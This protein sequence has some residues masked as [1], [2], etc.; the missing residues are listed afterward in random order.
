MISLLFLLTLLVLPFFISPFLSGI[1]SKS[2][3]ILR[4]YAINNVE[5]QTC[6]FVANPV[7]D[8]AGTNGVRVDFRWPDAEGGDYYLC[9]ADEPGP[10]DQFIYVGWNTSYSV[11]NLLQNRRYLW[12]V[13]S[14]WLSSLSPTQG[15]FTTPDCAPAPTNNAS[16]GGI[17]A[18]DSVTAGQSFSASVTMQNTG[19]KAWTTD[20]TPHNLG[21]QNLPDNWTWGT[22]RVGLPSSPIN[23]GQSATFSSNFT[24]PTTP[25]TY[26]FSWKMV[27]DGVDWFGETCSKNITV[28]ATPKSHI[29]LSPTSFSFTGVSGGATPSG[30]TLNIGNTGNATLGWTGSTNQ[31]WCHLSSG[32]G[33]ISAGSSQNITV[34]VDAPSNVGSFN[35]II[36]ISGAN[37]DNSPQT[38]SMVYTVGSPCHCS[39]C[40]TV[41]DRMWVEFNTTDSTCVSPAGFPVTQTLNCTC[42][43]SAGCVPAGDT[44]WY[45]ANYPG[46]CR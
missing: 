37:A 13:Y 20:S 21:S 8:L 18:S 24:A 28:S 14:V 42:C 30:Q 32:S 23:P 41:N 6:E 12:S 15:P 27:E 16:C 7:C 26:S 40:S 35:C 44:S 9:I 10:C 1:L 43:V 38:A 22:N 11:Y 39:R 2:G 36:T 17:T 31:N 33:S 19:T 25:N 5:A 34:T 29:V 3:E 45:N 46:V 4:N